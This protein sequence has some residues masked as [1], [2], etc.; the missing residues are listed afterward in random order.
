MLYVENV[1][2]AYETLKAKGVEITMEIEDLP[3]GKQ[4]A[5]KDLYGNIHVLAEPPAN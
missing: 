3:W 1:D 5:F 4:A 2:A